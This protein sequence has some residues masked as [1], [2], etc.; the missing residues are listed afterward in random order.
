MSATELITEAAALPTRR[1]KLAAVRAIIAA[2][3]QMK[4][5]AIE[6]ADIA[7]E[8]AIK[9]ANADHFELVRLANE[10]HDST[11]IPLADERELI[12]A[13]ASAEAADAELTKRRDHIA[14]LRA[15]L[16]QAESELAV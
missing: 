15:D 3:T 2:S 11:P 7:K 13:V 9:A 4:V 16:A 8:A 6:A 14:Q 12:V 10:R 1:E 5:A